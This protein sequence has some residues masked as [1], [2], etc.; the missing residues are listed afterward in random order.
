MRKHLARRCS[1][2]HALAHLEHCPREDLDKRADCRMAMLRPLRLV[3]ED[4]P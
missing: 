4:R 1:I 2:G 3:R